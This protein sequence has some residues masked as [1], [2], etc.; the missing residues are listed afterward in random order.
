MYS[1]CQ[2]NAANISNTAPQSVQ[3]LKL[4]WCRMRNKNH[5]HRQCWQQFA[6]PTCI[7]PGAGALSQCCWVTEW[8]H[9]SCC[10]C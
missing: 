10:W 2:H 3:P 7:L 8:G 6:K 5:S 4:Q 9:C 1:L